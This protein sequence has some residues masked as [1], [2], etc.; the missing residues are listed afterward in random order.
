MAASFPTPGIKMLALLSGTSSEK[1]GSRSSQESQYQEKVP[2]SLASF[3]S[4]VR[5]T[6]SQNCFR[7]KEEDSASGSVS[8]CVVDEKMSVGGEWRWRSLEIATH[9]R[10]GQASAKTK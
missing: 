9:A 1:N 4:P 3:R 8:G 7:P 6:S 10:D 2:S 5:Y